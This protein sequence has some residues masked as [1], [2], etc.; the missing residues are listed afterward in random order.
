MM[1]WSFWPASVPVEAISM[2]WSCVLWSG[3]V[4]FAVGFWWVH[5]RSVYKG[6]VVETDVEEGS[7]R[8]AV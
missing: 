8:G 5:G 7:G 6:P 3:V 4:M 2:N 1:F